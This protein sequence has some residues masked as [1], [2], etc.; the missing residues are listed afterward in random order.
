[1]YRLWYCYYFVPQYHDVKLQV[2]TVQEVWDFIQINPTIE[3]YL[4]S[5]RIPKRDFHDSAQK[6]N[7]EQHSE[8]SRKPSSQQQDFKESWKV[9]NVQCREP[10]MRP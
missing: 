2:N 5:S 7:V 3:Y 1:M 10:V 6:N 8:Q 9:Y 4:A